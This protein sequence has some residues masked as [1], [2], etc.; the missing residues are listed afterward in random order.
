[1]AYLVQRPLIV[2]VRAPDAPAY[3]LGQILVIK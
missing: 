3:A 2:P 1:M